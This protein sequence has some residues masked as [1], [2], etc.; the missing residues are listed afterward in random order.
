MDRNQR[1]HDTR[2]ALRRA[3]KILGPDAKDTEVAA[4]AFCHAHNIDLHF[5]YAKWPKIIPPKGYDDFSKPLDLEVY[6]ET[7][8]QRIVKR[9]QKEDA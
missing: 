1:E 6:C 9:F 4:I 5:R 8:W 3:I 2:V 7:E